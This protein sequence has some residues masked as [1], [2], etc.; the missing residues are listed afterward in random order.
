MKK[1]KSRKINFRYS[2]R[3]ED[4]QLVHGNLMT[5]LMIFFMVLFSFHYMKKGSDYERTLSSIQETFGGLIDNSMVERAEY[6]EKENEVAKNIGDAEGLK[7]FTRVETDRKKIKIIF[8]DPVIFNPGSADLK[9]DTMWILSEIASKLKLLPENKIIVEGHTDNIPLRGA[10]KFSSNWELSLARSLSI[11]HYL[12]DVEGMA[13]ERFIPIGYGANRPL[14]SNDT[15][16][17]RAQNRR[18]E[19]SIIKKG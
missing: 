10:G 1:N 15:P 2:A 13:P 16:E 14:F 18:I 11:V 4:W 6:R 12:I 8:P 17:D 19:I 5:I 9:F 7:K 3:S